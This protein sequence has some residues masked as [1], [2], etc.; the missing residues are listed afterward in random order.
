MTTA[1]ITYQS[2]INP[3]PDGKLLGSKSDTFPM[4]KS[5]TET[6]DAKLLGLTSDPYPSE[7]QRVS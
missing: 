5:L 1:S 4:R 2:Y 3:S 7:G 6:T